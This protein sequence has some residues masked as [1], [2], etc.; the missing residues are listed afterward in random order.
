MLPIDLR[1][2]F[3]GEGE[4]ERDRDTARWVQAAIGVARG[5][6][7]MVDGVVTRSRYSTDDITT[8]PPSSTS[9]SRSL[10]LLHQLG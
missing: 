9:L 6:N 10:S 5:V 4:E 2:N 3:C 7:P 8:S 1:P